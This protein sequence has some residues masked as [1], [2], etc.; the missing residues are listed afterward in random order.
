M[1]GEA[2]HGNRKSIDIY[3]VDSRSRCYFE[4]QHGLEI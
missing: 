3:N 4:P 1:R 2:G